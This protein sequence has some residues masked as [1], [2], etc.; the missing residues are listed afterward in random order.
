M[1]DVARGLRERGHAVQFVSLMAVGDVAADLRVE[2]FPV[3]DLGIRSP[4]DVPVAAWR[5]WRALRAF[6]PDLVQT[7]LFH[8]NILGRLVGRLLHVPVVSGYQSVDGD[9]PRWRALVDRWTAPL[10]RRHVAVSRAVAERVVV[11]AHIPRHR[12]D[13]VPI[14]KRTPVPADRAL[15][16]REW[17][18]PVDAVVVGFVG[19]LDPVKNLPVLVEAV[20][21]LPGVPWLLVVGDG[22]ERRVLEGR[23]RTV[24][25]GIVADTS[26]LY[27]AM[28]VFV[29]PSSREGMPGA[30][31]EAMAACLPV[32][33]TRVG[34]VPEVV[35]DRVDG[36]LVS[37]GA[38]DELRAAI[39]EALTRAGMGEAA[40]RTARERFSLDAMVDGYARAAIGALSGRPAKCDGAG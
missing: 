9:M 5:L 32:V 31:V 18:I 40:A 16:R 6:Q 38:P 27:A 25:T 21:S 2:D 11:R 7:A 26:A 22:S 20:E 24:V 17:G 30:L 23:P 39:V 36:I 15:V 13:V 14:G 1:A 8:A 19:R 4:R 37:P 34:G 29:L 12:I 3:V 33:A 35:T 10:A 28:D